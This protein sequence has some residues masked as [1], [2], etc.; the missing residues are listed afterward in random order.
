MI[1]VIACT[2]LTRHSTHRE[3]GTGNVIEAVRHTKAVMGEIRKIQ[4]LPERELFA[5]AKDIQAPIELVREVKQLGRLP[6]VNFAAG[7]I[8]TPADAALCMQ[9]GCDGVFVWV[10]PS[11]PVLQ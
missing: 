2:L 7:G 8:A 11:L 3:A 1:L 9:L 6:V 4:A 5:Y 10:A